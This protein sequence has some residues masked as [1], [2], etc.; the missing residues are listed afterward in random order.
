[1]GSIARIVAPLVVL[2]VYYGWLAWSAHSGVLRIR[3][4]RLERAKDP[5]EFKGKII[6]LAV[7]GLV[8]AALFAYNYFNPNPYQH[9]FRG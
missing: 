9:G 1:M 4:Y 3:G 8:M 5:G 6:G 2:A 7:I